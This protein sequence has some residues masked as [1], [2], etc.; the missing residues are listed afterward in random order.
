M[1]VEAKQQHKQDTKEILKLLS[2]E[3]SQVMQSLIKT[4][5]E[6]YGYDLSFAEDSRQGI[7]MIQDH[8]YDVILLDLAMPGQEGIQCIETIRQLP[9]KNKSALTIIA[10]TGNADF[11]TR[12]ELKAMGFDELVEKPADFSELDKTIRKLLEKKTS[13]GKAQHS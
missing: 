8:S 12:K 11:Y 2:I 10:L 5:L 9:D 7:K 3:D 13:K 4:S 1:P 6:V